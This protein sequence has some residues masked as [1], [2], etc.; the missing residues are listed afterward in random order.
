MRALGYPRLISLE[1][2]R[3]PN[4]VLVAS[5]LFWMVKRYD[6]EIH[7]SDDIDTE[8]DRVNFLTGVAQALASKA[9]IRLNTK[10]LYAADGKAAYACELVRAPVD[11]LLAD[12]AGTWLRPY[13]GAPT[14]AQR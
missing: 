10:R 2:F 1:N 14:T 9:K 4:F 6:P 11:Q 3:T 7:V 13:V 8:D 12:A 5:C